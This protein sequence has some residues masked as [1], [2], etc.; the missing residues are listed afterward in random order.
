MPDLINSLDLNLLKVFRALFQTRSTTR[1]SEVLNVSQSAVSR[2]L[3]KLRASFNDPLFEWGGQAMQPS[4]LARSLQPDIEAALNG[5]EKALSQ[6]RQFDPATAE[7]F[8]T[9]GLT[10]YAVYAIF[11]HLFRRVREEAPRVSINLRNVSAQ[12]A[13]R[14]LSNGHIEFAITSERIDVPQF[15]SDELFWEDYVV[16][17]DPRFV[18]VAR[19]ATLP[20]ETYLSHSH[21]LCSFTGDRQ[22]WVDDVLNAQGERRKVQFVFEGYSPLITNLAG[23]RLFATVPR[24]LIRYAENNFGLSHWELPFSSARHLFHL[25]MRSQHRLTPA[26]EWFRQI[27]LSTALDDLAGEPGVNSQAR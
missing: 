18:D 7:T 23:S 1:A 19:G 9:I 4:S 27:I 13:A 2:S 15:S 12:E 21:S 24:R 5:A 8:F 14:R 3:S 11:P 10:D 26:R 25:G 20:L 6:V 17:G 22:G 16:L